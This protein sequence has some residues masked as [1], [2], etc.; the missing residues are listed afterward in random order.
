VRRVVVVMETWKVSGYGLVKWAFLRQP[1]TRQ[2]TS[3][4][5][6]LSPKWHLQA[7]LDPQ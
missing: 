7:G 6:P 5:P 3:M 2:Q 1:E 4:T